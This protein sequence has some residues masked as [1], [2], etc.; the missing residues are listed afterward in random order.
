MII[1]D[2]TSLHQPIALDKFPE[3]ARKFIDPQ[4]PEVII[5]MLIDGL[6]PIPPLVRLCG[7]YQ[8]SLL[9]ESKR[10]ACLS[11][12]IEI[13]MNTLLP[14]LSQRLPASVLDWA[15]QIWM[16]QSEVM[17]VLISNVVCVEETLVRIAQM[18]DA[19]TCER[20][21]LNQ[22]RLLAYPSLIQA[23]YL[24]R[25]LRPS[26]ADLLIEFATRENVDLSWLPERDLIL[27]EYQQIKEG[28]LKQ[29][30]HL[31][32]E[33]L[34][35]TQE[36]DY[37]LSVIEAPNHQLEPAK[38]IVSKPEEDG[39]KLGIYARMQKLNISQKIRLALMGSQS[40]RGILVRDSNKVVARAAIRS[41]S[42]STQ[43]ALMYARNHAISAETIEF[44]ANHKKWMQNYQ[45]KYNIILNPK[46]PLSI[47]LA[48]V[49]TLNAP[50]LKAITK[51]HSVPAV[52]K[53][54]A[55]ALVKA[56]SGS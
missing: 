3:Q 31:F 53:Q 40:E 39:K 26:L 25:H 33:I 17:G 48:Q 43:E 45:V 35:E 44:I 29:D 42:V 27:Q 4:S 24:N 54:K 36:Q 11:K 6:V 28:V 51:S 20:L 10:E 7:L 49:S 52:V 5:N 30:D 46:T 14:V 9:F 15:S 19:H 56:K 2:W 41:P 37:H 55:E 22:Q 50:E 32:E 38:E 23:L 13:P 47:S 8:I 1:I 12:A 34:A 16:N 21:S 18:G